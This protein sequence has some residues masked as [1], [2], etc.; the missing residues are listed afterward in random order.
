[1]VVFNDYREQP[2]ATLFVGSSAWC[3]TLVSATVH[4]LSALTK[5]NVSECDNQLAKVVSNLL[6]RVTDRTKP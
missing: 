1:M 5:I 4:V 3:D 2:L 6:C